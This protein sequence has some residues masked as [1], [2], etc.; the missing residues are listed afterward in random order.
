MR[1]CSV[2]AFP[3]S[4]QEAPQHLVFTHTTELRLCSRVSFLPVYSVIEDTA[5]L[6]L[7]WDMGPGNEKALPFLCDGSD[8]RA[9][10]WCWGEEHKRF[11]SPSKSK[12]VN[13]KLEERSPLKFTF[14]PGVTQGGAATSLVLWQCMH[15][16]FITDVGLDVLCTRKGVVLIPASKS[17]LAFLSLKKEQ[18][19]LRIKGWTGLHPV[20]QHLIFYDAS[21]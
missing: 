12:P 13:Q 20:S 7:D 16:N 11:L 4:K 5:H 14:V 17:F 1:T 21:F 8:M 6:L 9:R 18:S 2:C 19:G 15:L 10:Q 3:A